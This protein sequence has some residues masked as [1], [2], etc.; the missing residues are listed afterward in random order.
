MG[1]RNS[2]IMGITPQPPRAEEGRKEMNE[3][4]FICTRCKNAH[5]EIH[6]ESPGGYKLPPP[7]A[8]RRV[9]G[10]R[11]YLCEKCEKEVR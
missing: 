3:K 9:K 1:E 6:M 5:E 11:G 4:R 2:D 7:K 10:E 8:L